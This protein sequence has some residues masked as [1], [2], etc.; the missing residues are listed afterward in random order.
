M[1]VDDDVRPARRP[2]ID[3]ALPT[4]L[5]SPSA[6]GPGSRNTGS[7]R[8]LRDFNQQRIREVL[9]GSGPATQAD[10]ARRTGLS[11]ATISNIV[12]RMAAASLVTTAPTTSSGR[13]ATLVSLNEDGSF[14][15]GIDF[16]RRHIRIILAT[17]G[18]TILAERFQDVPPGLS[19]TEVIDEAGRL[20]ERMLEETGRRREDLLGCGVGV[21]GPVDRRTGEIVYG[22]ILPEW[23]GIHVLDRLRSTLRTPVHLDND[24]NLGALAETTWGPYTDAHDLAF[25][26]VGSGIGMGLILRGELYYGNVGLT[27][28]LGHTTVVEQGQIC[29]CGSRGCLET[30]ASTSYML[31][32]LARTRRTDRP[33]TTAD[34]V[35]DA[36]AG[37]PA[38]RRVVADAGQAL[39]RAL[40]SMANILNPE[41]IIIGGPL[42]ALDGILLDPV[43]QGMHRHAIPAV[44]A[45]TELAMASLGDRAEALG[46]CTLAFQQAAVPV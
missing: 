11:T 17:P 21:P 8:A 26:K 24:A 2:G 42:A 14:A 33:L 27:G 34:L 40:A 20:L 31:D 6:L 25:V 10:L 44:S 39:G 9:A 28:E 4:P 19:A 37:D 13:K 35:A 46:A 45:T 41:L 23:V 30:V 43:R 15:A 5:T 36:S 12:K 1:P 32:L 7:Q 22:A 3:H 18:H 38:A 16:G 29:R